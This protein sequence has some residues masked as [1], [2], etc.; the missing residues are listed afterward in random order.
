MRWSPPGAEGGPPEGGPGDDAFGALVVAALDALPDV[1]RERLGSVAIVVE[2]EA[3][4]IN[5]SRSGRTACSASTRG[6]RGRRGRRTTVPIRA[7][8][9]SSGDHCCAPRETA[10]D[11]A[12]RVTETSITRLRTTSG[13]RTIGFASSATPA[14]ENSA[15]ADRLCSAGATRRNPQNHLPGRFHAGRMR[16]S[17]GPHERSDID[18]S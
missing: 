13:Y 14:A 6:C 16:A 15:A 10:D 4:R 12:R 2:E 7:R 9:R 3:P 1:F 5:C 18:P 11:L 8:S 17:V